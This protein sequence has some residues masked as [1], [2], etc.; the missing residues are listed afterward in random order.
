MGVQFEAEQQLVKQRADA[1][2][3]WVEKEL[4]AREVFRELPLRERRGLWRLRR[5]SMRPS[6][7]VRR[8]GRRGWRGE[9]CCGRKVVG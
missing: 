2:L 4:W 8:L 5:G 7:W 9:R 6:L 1:F 3:K